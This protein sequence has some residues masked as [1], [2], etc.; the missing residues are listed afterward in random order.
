MPSDKIT[1]LV[2][3]RE[4]TGWTGASI[5]MAIDQVADA[6]SLTVPFDPE[7]SDLRAAFRPFSYQTVKLYVGDDILLTG[8]IEKV[9]PKIDAGERTVTVQGRSLPGALVDC[10]IRGPL[11]WS[12]MRIADIAINVCLPFGVSVRYDNN[13]KPIELARAGYGQTAAAFLMS[14]ASPR[15]FFLN[16]SYEGQLVISS[17]SELTKRAVVAA[18]VE[19]EHPLLGVAASFDGTRRFST[20]E[21]ATQFAGVADIVGSV[22]DATMPVFEK[23]RIYR[24]H[25]AS[26]P[27]AFVDEETETT[28][29]AVTARQSRIE[30]IAA[31][32][33]VAVSV[34]GWRRPDGKRWAERQMVTLRAPGA[35]LYTERKWLIAGLSLKLDAATGETCDMRLVL[36][37]TYAWRVPEVL[38]WE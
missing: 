11:E 8:R 38:P 12:G 7:R 20:Y 30:A 5:E 2:G 32:I 34:S 15:N 28:E 24:P 3:S 36:P 33:S 21:V 19:G 31:S 35:M 13:S 9:E 37:E 14:V 26:V 22:E 23:K 4:I 6:F 29:P 25:L 27:E 1:L 18:L 17:G 10:A 16:S